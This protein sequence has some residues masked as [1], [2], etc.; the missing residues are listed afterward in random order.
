MFKLGRL[1][2][3]VPVPEINHLTNR[4]DSNSVN[5][6][7]IEYRPT[8]M[9]PNDDSGRGGLEGWIR[10]FCASVVD[11]LE[12]SE[13]IIALT[14]QYLERAATREDG[15]QWIFYTRLR[16]VATKPGS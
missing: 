4:T 2:A 8:K 14:C 12:K 11:G 9:T 5:K 3:L 16:G 10:L 6:M 7:E 1:H 15:S 13:D